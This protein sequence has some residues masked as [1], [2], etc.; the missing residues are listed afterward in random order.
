M[1]TS[2]NQEYQFHIDQSSFE[3]QPTILLP[4]RRSWEMPSEED[5]LELR[6]L[7]TSI[8]PCPM[9][10]KDISIDIASDTSTSASET[11]ELFGQLDDDLQLTSHDQDWEVR[12]LARELEKRE[13]KESQ[14]NRQKNDSGAQKTQLLNVRSLEEQGT[15]NIAAPSQRSISSDNIFYSSVIRNNSESPFRTSSSSAVRTSSVS[16]DVVPV[17]VVTKSPS[18]S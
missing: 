5:N 16:P 18:V 8:E 14:F 6:D 7:P 3:G 11:D 4:N 9:W 15:A 12:M 13:H 17:P 2:N 10:R 1:I